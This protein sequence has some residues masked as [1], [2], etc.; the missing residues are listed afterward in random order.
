MSNYLRNTTVLN[1]IG[2]KII[3]YSLLQFYLRL[4]VSLDI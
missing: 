2:S 1:K 4:L 3:H